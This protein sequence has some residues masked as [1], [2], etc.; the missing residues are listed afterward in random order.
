MG[1]NFSIHASV[2]GYVK[3]YRD[4]ARH[5]DRKYIGVVFDKA[6]TLPYP[7]HAERK[8][9]LLMRAVPRHEHVEEPE[10][11]RSGIPAVIRRTVDGH[12]NGQPMPDR[13]LRLRKDYSYREDNWRLGQ[14]VQTAGLRGGKYTSR[15]ARLRHR[16]FERER[17]IEGEKKAAE[18]RLRDTGDARK[19]VGKVAAKKKAGKKGKAVA[20]KKKV[21][22]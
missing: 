2:S 3:Y 19:A 9:R 12:A 10:V 13:V 7:A 1:R 18:R 15:H 11:S 5:P 4:P 17:M 20:G 16:R 6:D 21:K 8:R 14:M 22:A